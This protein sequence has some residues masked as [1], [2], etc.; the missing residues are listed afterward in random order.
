MLRAEGLCGAYGPLRVLEGIELEVES[1]RTFCVI[2]PSGCGKTTL[3]TILAGLLPPSGGR[4]L[5]D[6]RAVTAGDPRVGLILQ[7]YGLFPW[8]TA[9]GNV[10]VG[11][12]LRRIARPDRRRVARRELERVG[13]GGVAGRWPGQLSGGQKQRVA[14]AR[15]LALQPALLLMDEPFSALDEL[16]RE[17]LQDLLAGRLAE[18]PIVTVLVTHS[19]E[20]AVRLASSVLVLAPAG[21]GPSRIA[22]RLDLPWGADRPGRTDRAFF[23]ACTEVRRAVRQVAGQVVAPGAEGR[24]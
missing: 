7:H 11:L 15:T 10:E 20:E 17:G 16:T 22:A 18:R 14:I 12:K 19:V 8:M 23:E 2:G 1:G 9:A 5:L 3:L 24:P 6:G 21:C 4:V 13:L